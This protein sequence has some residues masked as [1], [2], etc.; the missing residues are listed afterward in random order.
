[1]SSGNTAALMPNATSSTANSAV[2]VP[3]ATWSRRTASSAMFRVPVA[4]YTS[5]MP[6]RKISDETIDT[7]T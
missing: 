7:M 1:M 5:A 3:G 2:R 4:A 6:S